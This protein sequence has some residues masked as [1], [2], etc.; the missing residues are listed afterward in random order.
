MAENPNAST[1]ETRA[2]VVELMQAALPNFTTLAE[3]LSCEFMQELC[4]AYGWDDVT[5]TVH[6]TTDY[7]IVE[8]RIRYLA[9]ALNHGDE[10]KFKDQVSEVTSFF[11]RRSAQDN[12]IHCC[13]DAEI[14]FA[15]VP[16]G[17]ETCAFCFMLASRGFVYWSEAAAGG[18]HKFH[19]H[20]TCVVVPGEKG[21]TKIDGYD[22]A[23][24]Y[25]NWK[26]CEETLG[27]KKQLREDWKALSDEERMIYLVKH[28]AK[29]GTGYDESEARAEYLRK[30]VMD[31][32]ETRDWHW[33][34]TG[35][36]TAIDYSRSPREEYGGLKNKSR[37]FNPSDYDES[38]VV[39]TGANEW[40]DLFAHDALSHGG[41]HVASRESKAL[42]PDSK[43]IDHVTTPDIEID[44]VLWEIKSVRDG[45][46]KSSN[47]L[48]FIEQSIRD[49]R[50]NFANPY[51]PETKS[52]MGDMRSQTRVVIS[53]RYRHINAETEAIEA[54]FAKRAE[55]YK[56]DVIWIDSM[57][58]IR[59]FG[60]K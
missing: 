59:R 34:Y 22:P 3:T 27:G 12:I 6:D 32:V 55:R 52:G 37:V 11:V 23:V 10:D 50:K 35:E 24:M 13:R 40:R 26:S 53:T 48:S 16:S 18:Q 57:G 1:A 9:E 56:V 8:R 5:P 41:F 2:F 36:D 39:D 49:A 42:G 31:E 29:Y 58:R 7:K 28:P 21:R 46:H 30:R 51:D 54:E 14:R 44:G 33:L 38:N 45:K 25:R 60:H 17:L 20:C 47:E 4:D 43:V 15:R 19:E